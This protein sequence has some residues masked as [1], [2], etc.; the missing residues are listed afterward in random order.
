[1]LANIRA[2]GTEGHGDY[3][4]VSARLIR[5]ALS[6]AGEPPP[7]PPRE[8]AAERR[9]P[10]G[11]AAPEPG[12]SADT[13]PVA[14]PS[15]TIASEASI[16]VD[17]GL[18][19]RLMDLAGELVLARNRLNQFA[20]TA[21]DIALVN[22]IQ[23]ISAITS[24]LQEGVMQTRMQPISVVWGKLPRVV[25]DLAVACGKEVTLQ[26]EGE[27]TELDRSLLEAIRDPLTHLIRNA[28]DHGIESPEERQARG[29]PRTGQVLLRAYHE[30]GLVHVEITDDG[31]G[32][33]VARVK[34]RAIERG[35][36]RAEQAATISDHDVVQLI[37]RPG[38]STAT[39]VTD[40]SGRGVGM[41][42]VKSN[43]ERIG[44]AI[45]IQN[46]PGHAATV[47]MTIPLTLAIIPALIV[48]SG[49]SRFAVPQVNLLE[50]LKV[51]HGE[52][53]PGQRIE[54][55]HDTPVCRLRG[56]LLPLVSLRQV[57]EFEPQGDWPAEARNLA[58]LQAEGR[59][60]GLL[61]DRLLNT[62]EIVVKPLGRALNGIPVFAGATILGDG[63]VVLILDVAGL[64]RHA[65]LTAVAA[66]PSVSEEEAAKAEAAAEAARIPCLLCESDRHERIAIR[67]AD[68]QRLEKFPSAAVERSASRE[69]V[70]YG[71]A[72]M[73]L[74]RLAK[75]LGWPEADTPRA[76]TLTVVVHGQPGNYV[77][78]IVPRVLDIVGCPP[79]LEAP[80]DQ[81]RLLSGSS[82]IEGRV[83]DVI[84]LAAALQSEGIQPA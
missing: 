66:E 69:A 77:G 54:W 67:L 48:D 19:D 83:T 36:I 30:S 60:F 32:I 64:A 14:A 28:V 21:D 46:R 78:V 9:E 6:P 55:I 70:Q 52:Q 59:R 63:A 33:D 79:L 50:L 13:P 31:A 34:Q 35:V 17:V 44:G 37:F 81:R 68:V 45:H 74:V 20:A 42:V 27:E 61:V 84:D 7:E 76:A 71:G 39:T 82:V 26:Q 12:D 51:K 3:Q 38:F 16:R 56:R 73:P 43:I 47:R 72:I 25:R 62:E 80:P 41:D 57:L 40:V 49:G 29:K 53:G 75:L 58:V 18:L 10:A 8:V 2:G 23:H 24:A 15:T 65:G 5:L 11:V 4:T 1:M 22:S